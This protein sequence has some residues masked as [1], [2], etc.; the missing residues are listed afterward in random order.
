MI[1]RS[2]VII[3]IGFKR[4]FDSN[5]LS[6]GMKTACLLDHCQRSSKK[7]SMIITIKQ[8]KA[9]TRDNLKAILSWILLFAPVRPRRCIIFGVNSLRQ[10]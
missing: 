10:A 2:G 4:V 1:N 8:T 3:A 7:A 9:A 6:A 5:T